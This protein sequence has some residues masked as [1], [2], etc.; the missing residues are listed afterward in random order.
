M[1]DAAMLLPPFR[2]L[3]DAPS[4]F[5]FLFFWAPAPSS[6]PGPKHVAAAVVVAL[7]FLEGWGGPCMHASRHAMR[8]IAAAARIRRSRRSTCVV[9][10]DAGGPIC[11]TRPAGVHVTTISCVEFMELSL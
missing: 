4:I 9:P 11:A 1:Q 2:P 7:A 6:N 10:P 5:L 8:S 3:P